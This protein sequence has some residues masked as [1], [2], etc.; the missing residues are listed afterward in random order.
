VRKS[1]VGSS[2]K[3]A[4]ANDWRVRFGPTSWSTSKKSAGC[5][6][7]TSMVPSALAFSP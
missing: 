6:A 5:G 2:R 3:S 1:G 4:S 7:I